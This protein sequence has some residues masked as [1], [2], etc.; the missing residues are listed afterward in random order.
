MM[1]RYGVLVALGFVGA[2]AVSVLLRQPVRARALPPAAPDTAA[3]T[4][5]V[6]VYPDRVVASPPSIPVGSTVALTARSHADGLVRLALAGYEDRVAVTLPFDGTWTTRFRA[7]RP[8]DP[9]AWLV[10]GEPAGRF[11]VSGSHMIEDHR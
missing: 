10:N 9:L 1:R 6:D 8:G 5:V 7:D 4:V 11:V 3:L 2:L